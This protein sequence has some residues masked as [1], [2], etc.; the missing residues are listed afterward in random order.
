MS[1]RRGYYPPDSALQERWS[2]FRG[3]GAPITA[4]TPVNSLRAS[5]GHGHAGSS[6]SFDTS[7]ET[8]AYREG[9]SISPPLIHAFFSV[10]QERFRYL[11]NLGLRS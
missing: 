1:P 8:T 5:E 6:S 3:T 2:A 4:M 9:Q 11:P 7:D 10:T